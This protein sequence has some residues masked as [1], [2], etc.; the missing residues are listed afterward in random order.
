[1][2]L[3]H[4]TGAKFDQFSNDAINTG[5]EVQSYGWGIYLTDSKKVAIGYADRAAGQGYVYTVRVPDS[6]N[7]VNWNEPIDPY[8]V[9]EMAKKI[10][11]M[12]VIDNEIDEM[13]EHRTFF[14]SD[15]KF[16]NIIE[17]LLV[18]GAD[19][20]AWEA[21]D[22]EIEDYDLSKFK[23]LLDKSDFQFYI[24]GGISY[25]MVYN[26][27]SD[28]LGGSNASKLMEVFEIDGFKFPS[29]EYDGVT[30]YTIF[31]ADNIKI[32]DVEGGSV[33][34]S[35]MNF[36]TFV[37]SLARDSNI[38]LVEAI[39]SGYVVIF[40][41]VNYPEG[42]DPYV[43]DK[44]PSFRQRIA[45]AQ[46]RL[47]RISSGSSRIVYKIDDN[48]VLKLAR[49]P[50]GI[51]QN[52]VESDGYI[53]SM[54]IV[55][56]VVDYSDNDLWL[57]SEYVDNIKTNEFG[58]ITGIPFDLFVDALMHEAHRAGQRGAYQGKVTYE[59]MQEL[60]ENDFFSE[61]I[62]VMTNMDLL[63]GDLVKLGS[64]GKTK[65]GDVVLRDA[66]FTFGVHKEHYS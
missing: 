58:Q 38:S 60:Y 33:N 50:K 2:E 8:I 47:P 14:Y 39:V 66:G 16:E 24:N 10:I 41:G 21:L 55:A 12:D 35:N 25:E 29:K 17:T 23:S 30:N 5:E 18:D 63:V 57:I 43:L 32:L 51:A 34:E 61:I 45:Y 65:R 6:L 59:Q 48:H 13:R 46:Q 28:T 64:Y 11:G 27:V 22:E 52:G 36:K 62:Q 9:S 37:K 15:D 42:F 26:Y 7:I 4:G 53:Q 49:N 3:Y 19:N 40:E 56:N 54:N 31:D 1:M 20:D 44:L